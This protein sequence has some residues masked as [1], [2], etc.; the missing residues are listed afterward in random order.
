MLL[1]CHYHPFPPHSL[2]STHTLCSTN[3]ICNLSFSFSPR[4]LHL[5]LATHRFNSL[6]VRIDSFRLPSQHHVAADSNFDSLLS[7]LELSCL[8]SSLVVSAAA[9][10][11]PASKKDLFAG[12]G[13][14][15]APLGLVMLVLGVSVGAW[16][17]RRQWRRVCVETRSGG[18]EVNLLERIE[19]LEQDLRSSVTVVRV[20]SRQ[21]EKLGIRFRVTRKGL[22]DPIAET[23]ALAQK[24]S[25]AA[26]ALA[27][28]SDI[29]EKELGE[30]QQVLLAM[31]EQQRK[32][33]DLILA[34][35]KAGKLW[36]SKH[37]ASE[38]DTL[39]MSDSVEDKVKQEVH[40]I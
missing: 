12:I 23:A 35:G 9:V 4:P 39:E 16:I 37:E 18:S 40:Q 38:D 32:Q 25:E 22:K 20:L 19:K 13:S 15:A 30:I 31:Q 34:I 6:T 1:T 7:L 2:S 10:A 21:L 3:R 36:D 8:L 11:L 33:L 17:R 5:S 26:R 24:N 27:V 14:K 28:Q 29:L